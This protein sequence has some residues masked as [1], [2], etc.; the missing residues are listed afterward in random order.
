MKE[1]EIKALT[2]RVSNAIWNEIREYAESGITF[3]W[4]VIFTERE[5]RKEIEI[6][7]G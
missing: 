5:T 2:R 1:S 7:E 4:E 3:E 6:G